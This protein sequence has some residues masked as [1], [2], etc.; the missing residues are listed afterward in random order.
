MVNNYIRVVGISIHALVK[1]ATIKCDKNE[2]LSMISIHALVKRAT[3]QIT[4]KEIC[5]CISIHA[6]VKRATIL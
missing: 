1:R 2:I 6:L 4:G 3:T 5:V